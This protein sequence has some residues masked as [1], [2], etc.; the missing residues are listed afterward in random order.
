MRSVRVRKPRAGEKRS[1]VEV[2]APSYLIGGEH[3]QEV[4]KYL[5]SLQVGSDVLFYQ[6]P[7]KVEGEE[8]AIREELQTYYKNIHMNG[9]MVVFTQERTLYDIKGLLDQVFGKGKKKYQV[10]Y[11]VD[12]GGRSSYMNELEYVLVYEKGKGRIY[13]ESQQAYICEDADGRRYKRE[14]LYKPYTDGVNDYSFY[15]AGELCS[16]PEGMEWQYTKERLMEYIKTLA[17]EIVNGKL[18]KKV[19]EKKGNGEERIGEL[20]TFYE[21]E[22]S[23]QSYQR[24][25][26]IYKLT[27]HQEYY[28]VPPYVI[29][30]ILR[31]ISDKQ[32]IIHAVNDIYGSVQDAIGLLMEEGYRHTY[33]SYSRNS[34]SY[35]D[36]YAYLLKERYIYPEK[37]NAEQKR[38]IVEETYR[39]HP[40]YRNTGEYKYL[41]IHHQQYEMYRQMCTDL[42]RGLMFV[43]IKEETS[44]EKYK[45]DMSKL[46]YPEEVVQDVLT[47]GAGII[48]VGREVG[49]LE[50]YQDYTETTC[51]IYL[52]GK[53]KDE[54]DYQYSQDLAKH[55]QDL[56]NREGETKY[57][58]Y[59]R[60][61]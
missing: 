39:N 28:A 34:R 10:A 15:Y 17:V 35:S 29:A 55:Y 11:Q 48:M 57:T 47:R 54:Q 21:N 44:S 53:V 1:N 14:S 2:Y 45:R 3:E 24:R 58:E 42:K 41:A 51:T 7:K 40:E 4:A 13:T 38:Q 22:M 9:Y 56:K 5:H 43:E 16:L 37:R 19:Y 36:S 26:R 33:Y 23:I 20:T 30:G 25:R 12:R 27:I 52:C 59:K 60:I 61:E 46:Y 8:E 32:A 31:E 18:Y 6:S 49:N 50:E